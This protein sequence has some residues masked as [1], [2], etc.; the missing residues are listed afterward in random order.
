M[1]YSQNNRRLSVRTGVT[2]LVLVCIGLFLLAFRFIAPNT[3]FTLV[4]PLW[5]LPNTLNTDTRLAAEN[6]EL[7]NEN[8]ALKARL[9]DVGAAENIPTEAGILVG[10]RARPPISPY[11]TLVLSNGTDIGVQEGALVFGEGIP[12]GRVSEAGERYAQV[13]LFSSSG[14]TIEG[15]VGE[16]REPLTLQ[17]GGAGAF[18]AEVPREVPVQ[19]GDAVYLP[20]GGAFPIAYV[21]HITQDAASP[22]VELSLEPLVNIFTLTYVR[23]LP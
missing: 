12:I 18:S 17:G 13:R 23:I 16:E 5:E 21:R 22:S 19:E 4:T 20:A 14:S 10:V 8:E 6:R 2:T 1:R 7:R 9:Q 11:D 3:F 15:W